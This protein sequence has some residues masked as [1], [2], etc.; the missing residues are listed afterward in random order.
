MK[1]NDILV[2][3]WG[4]EQTNI[5][6]YKVVSVTAKSVKIIRIGNTVVKKGEYMSEYVVPN[7]NDLAG[8][9]VVKRVKFYRDSDKQYVSINTYATAHLWDGTPKFQSYWH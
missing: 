6:F 3:S 4:Y 1:V 2:S 8:E 9:P 7:L 5:D